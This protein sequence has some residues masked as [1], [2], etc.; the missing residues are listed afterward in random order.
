[1]HFLTLGK[2]QLIEALCLG[3]VVFFMLLEF[4]QDGMEVGRFFQAGRV[5]QL[6]LFRIFLLAC[7][8][9]GLYI[10]KTLYSPFFRLL[11]LGTYLKSFQRELDS[12]IR[13]VGICVQEIDLHLVSL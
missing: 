1:V 3:V 9:T 6:H 2:S 5:R 7:L 13:L 4:G 10:D 11:L 12:F 8:F